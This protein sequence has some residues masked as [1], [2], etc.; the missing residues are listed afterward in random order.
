[1]HIII[2]FVDMSIGS[3]AAAKHIAENHT[4]RHAELQLRYYSTVRFLL[5]LQQPALY[6]SAQRLKTAP[7]SMFEKNPA[8]F[9]I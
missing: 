3:T 5:S 2:G 6:F 8:I 9:C 7:G 4:R 1:M